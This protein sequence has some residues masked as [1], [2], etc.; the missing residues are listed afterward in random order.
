MKKKIFWLTSDNFLD[1]DLP[2]VPILSE[3]FDIDWHIFISRQAN[4]FSESE[5]LRLTKGI[6]GPRIFIFRSPY[7]YRS[8]HTLRKFINYAHRIR[9]GKYDAV[10]INMSGM[11]Y[12]FPVLR[13]YGI[14]NVI[15][16]CHDV[17][18]HLFLADTRML[19]AYR[20]FIFRNFKNFQFFSY[21]QQA[22]FLQQHQDKHTFVAPLCL[23]DFGKPTV[24]AEKERVVFTFFGKVRKSK[25]LDLLIEAGEKL[26]EKYAGRFIISING[27]CEDW[28]SAYAPMIRHHEIF[29]L[30]IRDIGNEEIPDIMSAAHYIVL[31]YLDVT[32][33]GPL[34]IAYSYNLPAIA[35]SHPGFEE[36]IADNDTGFIFKNGDA[37]SL[38]LTMEK[39]INDFKNYGTL[40]ER[41]SAYISDNL[42][43]R[44]IGRRYTD[45]F[46]SLSS[47]P[48]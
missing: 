10:Y 24:V 46:N 18:D 1:V 23:K 33:S 14:K 47:S 44:T 38:A 32:Q 16:A 8:I 19:R 41:L 3:E 12:L 40:K 15:Y 20:N 29:R 9:T 11:P 28:E 27:F 22:I 13:F 39:V 6:S 45:F 17:V 5:A 25:G 4:F 21:S 36:L 48:S 30:N 42:A 34:A 35:S 31:P 37:D 7:R 2:L 26:A 43:I